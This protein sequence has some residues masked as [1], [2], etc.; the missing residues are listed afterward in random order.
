MFSFHLSAYNADS[1]VKHDIR[2]NPESLMGEKPNGYGTL[3]LYISRVC[4]HFV[5]ALHKACSQLRF[6]VVLGDVLLM[7]QMPR[8]RRV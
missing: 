4:A 3:N 1:F 5:Q 2:P 8:G 6:D 7:T